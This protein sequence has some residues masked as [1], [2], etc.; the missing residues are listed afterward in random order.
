MKKSTKIIATLG[1]SSSSRDVIAMMVREGADGFRVNFSHGSPQHWRAMASIVRS[2]EE[3]AARPIA[4][5]GDLTGPAVRLGDFEPVKVSRGERVRLVLSG[6]GEGIPV[7]LK[8]LFEVVEEG[9]ELLIDEG[10]IRLIVER[11]G[12]DYVEAI[13]ILDGVIRPRK[14]LA[15][16]G[17]DLGL[18]PLTERDVENARLAV[19]MGFDYLA[20]SFVRSPEDVERLR[21]ALSRF[22]GDDV[23]IVAKIETRTA[24]ENVQGIARRSDAVMVARGDL[25]VHFPLE[26]IPSIQSKI[27][28]E[29]LSVGKPVILATQL[30][31]SMVDSPVPTRSEVTDVMFAVSQGAD[32]L[33]LASETAVGRYPIEAVRWM[34]R[35][36]ENAENHWPPSVSRR[37]PSSLYDRF[38]QGVA[39]LTKSLNARVAVYTRSGKTALRISTFREV[40]PIFAATNSPRVARQM[41]LVW[42]IKPFVVSSRDREEALRELVKLLISEGEVTYGDLLVAAYG[43]REGATEAVRIIQV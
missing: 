16:A 35:I 3:A 28:E 4:L 25:G 12:V 41:A 22:G 1:P 2:V 40:S 18:P 37:A 19:D 24:V 20:M 31:E 13:S 17:R 6:R 30:L 43:I 26:E 14:S 11:V 7:P 23:R 10:K 33:L 8:R 39:L 21:E 15:I 34:R 9:D 5:L 27:I 32:A 36:I 42:G 38:A 29:T